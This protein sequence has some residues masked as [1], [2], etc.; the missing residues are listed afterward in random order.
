MGRAVHP[1]G[2]TILGI[3]PR[4]RMIVAANDPQA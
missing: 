4:W 1:S 2:S 3:L